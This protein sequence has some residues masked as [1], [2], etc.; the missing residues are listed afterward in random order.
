MIRAAA[1]SLFILAAALGLA[2]EFVERVAPR[3]TGCT[4]EVGA[5]SGIE[6]GDDGL[7]IRVPVKLDTLG[8]S[9]RFSRKVK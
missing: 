6:V 8:T 2:L 3:V 4:L 1:L 5:A 9:P 7:S